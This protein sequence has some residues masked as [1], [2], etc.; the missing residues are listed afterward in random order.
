MSACEKGEQWKQARG[1]TGLV[2]SIAVE[3][4]V[5]P[6][7]GWT[8]T[9]EALKE[10]RASQLREGTVA[11]FSTESSSTSS[12]CCFASLFR[13]FWWE[14]QNRK[15]Q[16]YSRNILYRNLPKALSFYCVPAFFL[17]FTIRGPQSPSV[18]QVSRGLRVSNDAP[19]T[20]GIRHCLAVHGRSRFT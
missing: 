12:R 5:Q 16:E 11:A 1:N 13:G 10:Y 14:P 15:R 2:S 20:S 8:W 7:Q 9:W 3:W 4:V 6:Y 18:V 17:K 19:F